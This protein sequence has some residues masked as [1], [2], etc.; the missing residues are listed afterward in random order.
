MHLKLRDLK[1]KFINRIN[2]SS[3]LKKLTIAALLTG[4]AGIVAGSAYSI[5][6]NFSLGGD[7]VEGYAGRIQLNPFSKPLTTNSASNNQGF[8][9]FIREGREYNFD[10]GKILDDAVLQAVEAFTSYSNNLGRRDFSVNFSNINSVE[11][12][13]ATRLLNLYFNAESLGEIANTDPKTKDDT[14]K[15][16]YN[17]NNA[18]F[19]YVA[20]NQLTIDRYGFKYK[21]DGTATQPASATPKIEPIVAFNDLGTSKARILTTAQNSF[22]GIGLNV[23]QK[24]I[25]AAEIKI[26]ANTN[27]NLYTIPNQFAKTVN[28][29]WFVW[30]DKDILAFKLNYVYQTY[31]FNQ[32]W[33]L[34][35]GSISS[36]IGN[37]NI[38]SGQTEQQ[39]TNY[40]EIRRNFYA[41]SDDEKK[42]AEDYLKIVVNSNSGTQSTT[43]AANRATTPDRFITSDAL[44]GIYNNFVANSG[45]TALFNNHLIGLVKGGDQ[46]N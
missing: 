21:D 38:A 7:Y 37:P 34:T 3:L 16:P 19:H 43:D 1:R 36:I 13:N 35:A 15:V 5:V 23:Y 27:T 33:A 14:P 24:N 25:P 10:D 6:Q 17:K 42:F 31:V 28:N 4:G 41:L 32:D 9:T 20:L 22:D 30:L 12:N 26:L 44:N 29:N 45:S 39:K 46:G 11:N 8:G 18:W 2:K 40:A